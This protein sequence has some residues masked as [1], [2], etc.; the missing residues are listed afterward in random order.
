MKV[1]DG[2][3]Y[4]EVR[5]NNCHA[6]IGYEYIFAGRF[7]IDKCPKCGTKSVFIFKHMR[8]QDNEKIISEEFG[9][10]GNCKENE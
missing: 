3:P 10:G 9:S 2:K 1:I 6:L 7:A 5:C 8:T 4:R